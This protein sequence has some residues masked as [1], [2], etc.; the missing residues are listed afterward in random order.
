M[1]RITPFVPSCR[2]FLAGLPMAAAIVLPVLSLSGP[3]RADTKEAT[4]VNLVSK[5]IF[6]EGNG[7]RY[8]HVNGLANLVADVRVI[9]DTGTAGRVKSWKVSIGLKPEKADGRQFHNYGVSKHYAWNERPR[10]VDRTERVIVPATV[11]QDFVEGQCNGLADELRGLGLS[12]Q[13]IFAQDRSLQLLVTTRLDADTTGAGSGTIWQGATAL[14][15]VQVVCKRWRGSAIPQASD[16]LAVT[17]SKVVNKGL[18]I[19]EQYGVTGV[20]KIRLDGWITTDQKGATVKFRYRNQAGKQSRVWT[21]NTG[22]SKT[23]TFSHWYHIQ[24]TEWAETGSVRIVGVSHDFRSDWAEYTMECVEGGPNSVTTI[25]PPKLTMTVVP[26]GKIMVH[27]QICPERLKLVGVIEGRGSYSG[28]AVFVAKNGPLFISPPR[29]YQI[30]DGQKTLVGADYPL[31]WSGVGNS[32][33]QPLRIERFFE[34]SVTGGGN[35]PIAVAQG[36]HMAVCTLPAVNPVVSGGGEGGEAGTPA[37]GSAPKAIRKQPLRV[38]PATPKPPVLQ[39]QQLK[40][41]PLRPA[42]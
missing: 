3:A 6:L 10:R 17:P 42:N 4:V 34:F 22:E 25:Q 2:R 15:E 30:A 9:V 33:N 36:G 37:A 24:N 16:S 19:Y 32:G 31:D 27:G 7:S 14:K 38:Q 29:A 21:V 11:W 40:P 28:H 12:D 39:R 41:L 20:C 5:Q 1:P 18:S 35:K 26:Q 23:A 8:S 13:Q